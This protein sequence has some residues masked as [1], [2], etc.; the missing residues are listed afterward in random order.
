MFCV[1]VSFNLSVHP[2]VHLCLSLFIYKQLAAFREKRPLCM[3]I[4]IYIKVALKQYFIRMACSRQFLITFTQFW[5]ICFV[6]ISSLGIF[7]VVR[8]MRNFSRIV[9]SFPFIICVSDRLLY[10]FLKLC[11]VLLFCF[12]SLLVGH[13]FAC[14]GFFFRI[15]ICI[16][17]GGQFLF[18]HIL[19][20]KS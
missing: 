19:V 18:I 15:F 6:P 17:T 20:T 11:C 2:S 5:I 10:I 14:A 4:Y 9:C 13:F 1:R 8:A 3:F 7:I 12:V 16:S